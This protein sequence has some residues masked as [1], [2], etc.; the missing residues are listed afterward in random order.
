[1]GQKHGFMRGGIGHPEEKTSSGA[2]WLLRGK[3]F[4]LGEIGAR[5]AKV[6]RIQALYYN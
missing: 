4:K 2:N 1:M 3:I 6:R 5:H